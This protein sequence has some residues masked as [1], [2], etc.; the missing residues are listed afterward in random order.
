MRIAI[1]AMGGDHAPS[2]IVLG[3]LQAAKEWPDTHLLLVGDTQ[4]IEAA[5]GGN[6]PSNVEI[7]HTDDV[8]GPDDEPVRAVRRKK[9]ASMVVAGNLVREGKAAAMLS[10]G[11]TG[12][13]MTTGLLIVGRI[14][15]IERPA[16]APMLPTMDDVGML[17]LDLGANMD[18]K[19]EHLLQYAIMGSI[20]RTKVHGMSNPRVGLLNVGTEAMK[21]NELTKAAF[22]LLQNAPINFI[23]NVESRDVLLRNC[24]VLICD[25]FAGNIMLK[26]MEGTATV[27]M[28]SVRDALTSSLLTKIAALLVKPKL[29]SLR[30]KMDYKEHGAGPL[31]GV[32]GLVLKCHGSSNDVAVKNAVG[33]ARIAIQ[34]KLVE[35]IATEFSRK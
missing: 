34:N 13:L 27:V 30:A 33:K 23:G 24:D 1:D 26:S 29:Q 3:A 8:I 22:E 12:A 5:M 25:G 21:G 6:K 28:R 4:Q 16:L 18:A 19:P 17:A 14:E 32:N 31:L 11:N 35:S 2:Q 9:G 15:G 10:A 7:I 20:Y